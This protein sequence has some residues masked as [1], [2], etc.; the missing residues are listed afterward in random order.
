M[1]NDTLIVLSAKLIDKELQNRFGKIPPILIPFESRRVIDYIYEGAKDLYKK[2]VIVGFENS[3]LIKEHIKK[4][5]YKINLLE[6]DTL[7]DLGYSLSKVDLRDKKN[8]TVLF[9][10][11]LLKDINFKKYLSTDSFGYSKV[12]DTE[13]W[14]VFSTK[15]NRLN[16][17]DKKE[18]DFAEVYNCFIGIFNFIDAKLLENCL[19]ESLKETSDLDSFYKMIKL[20]YDKRN[21]VKLIAENEWLDLGHEDNYLSSKKDV[22]ARYFNT[23]E[24]DKKKGILKKSSLEREKFINEVKWYLKLPSELQYVSPRIFD[25][26]LNYENPYVKMEYYSY[27]TIHELYLWGNYTKHKW[28]EIFDVLFDTHEEFTKYKLTLHKSKISEMLK[29]IYLNKTK[30]RLEQL[31][32]DVNFTRYFKEKIYVNDIEYPNLSE[33]LENL[34]DTLEKNNLYQVESLNIIHGDYFF[35]NILYD[36]KCNMVRLIDPR[37]DF[38]GYGIYGDGSYDLAKLS[39][40]VDGRYD[41]IVEDLFELS[42]QNNSISYK[43]FSSDKH[44]EIKKLFYKKLS[45]KADIR[46]IKLIQALLFLS[47]IPLH[48]DYPNRQKVMLATG[49]ELIK[50]YL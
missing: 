39:H 9:G 37:G 5:K 43:I 12:K 7:K 48:K 11:T 50:E 35:A 27:N 6:L 45:R 31:K 18:L 49:L 19:N 3:S 44:E 2:V 30:S 20:Y 34:N 40:S 25:Y 36:S 4:K 1:K 22:E 21:D 15:D 14:T 8:V 24:I 10:D 33:I 47:M 29:E 13:R 42:E 41:F 23:I 26:S 17:Y 38:G 32:K 46:R 28:E 16:L